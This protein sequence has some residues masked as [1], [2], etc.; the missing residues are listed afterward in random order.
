MFKLRKKKDYRYNNFWIVIPKSGMILMNFW[1]YIWMFFKEVLIQKNIGR[2][3]KSF[4][5]SAI[6]LEI[7]IKKLTKDFIVLAVKL[8]KQRR[9]WWVGFVQY[10]KKNLT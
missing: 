9:S 1:V 2:G 4:G 3:Y 7:F 8:L 10:I 6:E 5:N